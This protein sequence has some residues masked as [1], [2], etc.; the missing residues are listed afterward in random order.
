MVTLPAGIRKTRLVGFAGVLQRFSDRISFIIFKTSNRFSIYAKWQCAK[1][2]LLEAKSYNEKK[3]KNTRHH[4][5]RMKTYQSIILSLN[6][7][8]KSPSILSNGPSTDQSA[9]RWTPSIDTNR[10]IKVKLFLYYTT[11]RVYFVHLR[12]YIANWSL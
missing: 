4:L 12:D 2:I 3:K 8:T 7:K 6:N 11:I 9:C 5:T 10:C 1:L